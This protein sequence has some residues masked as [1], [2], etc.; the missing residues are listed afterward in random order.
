M[1]KTTTE[2]FIY[3][4]INN[5]HYKVET[6]GRIVKIID[7]GRASFNLNGKWYISDVFSGDGDAEGQ[8]DYPDSPH[9]NPE[10]THIPINYSF[11]LVRLAT[12]IHERVEKHKRVL[13]LINK[14]MKDDFGDNIISHSDDFSLY[15]HISK[16]CHNAKP[17][18]VIQ[19]KIFE[20]LTINK[21]P[22]NMNNDYY[23]DYSN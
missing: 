17:S 12:T 3:Y 22:P 5:K 1:F 21:L 14:W 16:Y 10:N 9:F 8:F 20:D 6:F 4:T 2:K 18:K 19:D 15:I 7:F 13:K 23:F 11:D